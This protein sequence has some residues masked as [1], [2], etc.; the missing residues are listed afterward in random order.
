MRNSLLVAL[1]CFVIT[2][3]AFSQKKGKEI[4]VTG[5]VVETQCYVTGLTGPGKGASHKECALT[6][7]KN[8]IPLAILEDATNTLFVA[9]QTKTSQTGANGMLMEYVADKVKATGRVYEKGGVKMIILSKVDR[10]LTR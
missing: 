3:M 7:A 9:G 4:T 5:E 6:C 10:V 8:G 2:T 1:C